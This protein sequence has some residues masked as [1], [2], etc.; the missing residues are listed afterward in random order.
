MQLL[1]IK[2]T[3]ITAY[4]AKSDGVAKHRNRTLIDQQA[5]MLCSHENEWDSNVRQAAYAYRTSQHRLQLKCLWLP[6]FLT[7]SPGLLAGF[8]LSVRSTRSQP[9]LLPGL[10]V[11]RV[12]RDKLYHDDAY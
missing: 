10:I 7:L 1:G 5:E 3:C 11:L 2:R 6:V 12:S 9:S 4:K 8:A